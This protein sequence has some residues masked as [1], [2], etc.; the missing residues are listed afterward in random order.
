MAIVTGASSGIGGAV[1]RAL[2]AAGIGVALVARRRAS[3]EHVAEEIVAAGGQAEVIAADLREP[4][5]ARE[6]VASA[7]ARLGRLDILVNSAGVARYS[8]VIDG[9]SEDWQEMWGINVLALA[10]LSR[11]AIASFP[12]GGGHV[13]HL[14]SLSGHRVPPGGGFYAATKFAVRAHAEALRFELRARGDKTRVTCVS[15][16]FVHTPLAEEYLQ[17]AG[18]T[19]ESL[20]YEAL[21][22]EDVA[23]CVLHALTSPASVEVNDILVRP[24]G[25]KT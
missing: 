16:G 22:P 9:D 1:A 17:G 5:A 8:P 4:E 2:G 10:R 25:Q 14:G 20:G 12:E 15:P 6:V 21:Q 11:E 19:L 18:K 3:L 24:A 23:R 7:V 13:L